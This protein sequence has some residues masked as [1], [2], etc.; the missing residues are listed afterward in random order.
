MKIIIEL[1][2]TGAKQPEIKKETSV[3]MD[4]PVVN[5]ATFVSASPIDAGAARVPDGY[6]MP[7]SD[8]S[9]GVS[10]GMESEKPFSTAGA[11][12]AGSAK[13]PEEMMP[14]SP[15]DASAGGDQGSAFST[16]P[17]ANIDTHHN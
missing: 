16:G 3:A 10:Q 17:F 13:I 9:P 7:S 12:D 6:G 2:D 8:G 5:M 1:D 15:P 14:M 11:L 4:Q